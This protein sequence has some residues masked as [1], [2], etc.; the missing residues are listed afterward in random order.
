MKILIDIWMQLELNLNTWNGIKI[1]LKF[2]LKVLYSNSIE[3]KWKANWSKRNW[4]YVCD[5]GVENPKKHKHK[6]LKF[7]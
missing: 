6:I 2:N 7:I 1:K 3:K 4:K 5:C